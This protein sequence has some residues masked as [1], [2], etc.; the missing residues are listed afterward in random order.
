[1]KLVYIE[2]I[3][4]WINP[5]HVVQVRFGQSVT[6]G[7]NVLIV[8]VGD[9]SSDDNYHEIKCANLNA[10]EAKML[11]IVNRLQGLKE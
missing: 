11:S 5:D 4:A 9:T 3:G 7:V 6:N 10:A 1:M 2:E 8:L